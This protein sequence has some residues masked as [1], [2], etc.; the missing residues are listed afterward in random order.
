MEE[1]TSTRMVPTFDFRRYIIAFCTAPEL[2]PPWRPGSIL[3]I[4][5]LHVLDPFPRPLMD[6]FPD[7]INC[8]NSALLFI[9]LASILDLGQ[10]GEAEGKRCMWYGGQ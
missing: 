8:P 6:A 4:Y 3:V 1:R 2:V 10:V 7:P 9:F 5:S